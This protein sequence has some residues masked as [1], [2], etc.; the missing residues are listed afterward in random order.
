MKKNTFKDEY[1]EQDGWL[2]V[3]SIFLSL[4]VLALFMSFAFFIL[5][6]VL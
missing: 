4:G 3:I 2:L 5:S 1:K 6:I